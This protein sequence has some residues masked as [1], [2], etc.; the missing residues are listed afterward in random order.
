MW[1]AGEGT[2]P[3]PHWELS[4]GPRWQEAAPWGQKLRL[5]PVSPSQGGPGY[6]AS[7]VQ[8]SNIDSRGTLEQSLLPNSILMS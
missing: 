7:P 3:M 8:P 6:L 1:G 5:S 4:L 2:L